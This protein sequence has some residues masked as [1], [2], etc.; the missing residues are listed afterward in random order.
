M[1]VTVVSTL[2][3]LCKFYNKKLFKLEFRMSLFLR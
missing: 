3:I 1:N 2:E